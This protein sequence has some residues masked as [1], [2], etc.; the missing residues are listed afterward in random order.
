MICAEVGV[1]VAVVLLGVVVLAS[2]RLVQVA[3]GR[4]DPITLGYIL[5]CVDV[6]FHSC[7]LIRLWV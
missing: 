4:T 3:D 1:E 7:V 2:G 6:L 5:V